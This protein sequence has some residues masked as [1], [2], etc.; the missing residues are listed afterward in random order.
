MN[1]WSSR[2]LVMN[3]LR[4]SIKLFNS[5]EVNEQSQHLYTARTF[6]PT[7]FAQYISL[8]HS[9]WSDTMLLKVSTLYQV[10]G[11]EVGAFWFVTAQAKLSVGAPSLQ[12][13]PH[14]LSSA[15]ASSIA[16]TIAGFGF[17]RFNTV[18]IW[19]QFML[20][21][22]WGSNFC[23]VPGQLESQLGPPMVWLACKN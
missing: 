20:S 6:R 2:W 11:W 9:Q 17:R 13:S 7:F 16:N 23:W 14:S 18:F 3:K 4:Q 10:L 1:F 12:T 8:A 22:T 21:N 5:L 15:S 19:L